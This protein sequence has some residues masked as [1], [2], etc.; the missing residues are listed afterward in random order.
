MNR[1]I[2]LLLVIALL[3][4]G[5]VQAGTFILPAQTS[6]ANKLDLGFFSGGTELQITMSG[7]INL[8]TTTQPWITNPDGS[9]GQPVTYPGY[10]YANA[11]ASGYPTVDG[12]DGINHFPGGGANFDVFD[13]S[14]YAF[15]GARRPPTRPT[16][17]R[18]GS[19][20]W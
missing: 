19:A 15:A 20:A 14:P 18:S 7:Q 9:L 4:R 12:G 10:G 1:P 8:L 16:L 3:W 6:D 13:V 17:G 2:P 5:Q 11:G